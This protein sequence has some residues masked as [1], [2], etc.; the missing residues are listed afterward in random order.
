MV[1]LA[2]ADAQYRFL[3][4]DIGAMGQAS[5]GGIWKRCS[6]CEE[7]YHPSNSLHIPAPSNISED[8][9]DVPYFLLG[10]DAFPL[11]EHLL[12]PYPYSGL[13]KKQRVFNYRLSRGRRVIENTFGI[14]TSKFQIFHRSIKMLPEGVQRVIAACVVLHNMCRDKCGKQYMPEGSVDREVRN[15]VTPGAWRHHA[16]PLESIPPI[17]GRNTYKRAKMLRDR[18]ADYFVTPEGELPWQYQSAHV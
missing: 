11:T 8:C 2:I 17:A 3:Y 5:D 6:F 12:K 18:M 16:T 15:E 1:L 7:L 14:L 13:T 4:V 10:D 9:T